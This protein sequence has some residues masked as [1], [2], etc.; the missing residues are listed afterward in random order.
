MFAKKS[1]KVTP[2]LVMQALATVQEP[3][4]HRDLV[5]LDMVKDLQ[6]QGGAVTFTI[7]L[8]TPACPLRGVIESD[9]R[10]AV[11]RVPG[12]EDVKIKWD[13]KVTANGRLGQLPMLARN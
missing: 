8:T 5:T 2:E 12:V 3:E 9:A 1:P 7:Q 11:M 10:A 13:A 4:L 6:V